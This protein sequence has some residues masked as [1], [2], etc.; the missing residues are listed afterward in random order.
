MLPAVNRLN[1][2]IK[3]TDEPVL[4]AVVLAFGVSTFFHGQPMLSQK[5]WTRA[6]RR[7]VD[8]EKSQNA[9][10]FMV[11]YHPSCQPLWQ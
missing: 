8:E 6:R 7:H 5:G 2:T 10:G 1:R 3:L 9:V 11:A 4:H